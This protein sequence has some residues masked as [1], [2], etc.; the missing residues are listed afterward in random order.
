[1]FM[2]RKAFKLI[3]WVILFIV[4]AFASFLGY[5]TITEFKPPKELVLGNHEPADTINDT[6]TLITWNT[7]YFGLGADMDFFYE[8]GT[9][10]RPTMGQYEQYSKDVLE[11]IKSFNYSDFLLLQEVDTLSHRSYRNNQLSQIKQVLP[12]F[13]GYFGINYNAWVPIPPAS[14]MGKVKAGQV[15][16]SKYIPVSAKRVAFESSYSWPMRLF[17]LKRCY[18]ETR[19][20]TSDGKELVLINTHNSAFDDAAALREKELNNLKQLINAEYQ[21]GNYVIVGGD[22][23]QNPPFFDSAAVLPV[24]RTHH[25]RPG[26]PEDFL[27]EDWVVAYDPLHTTNRNVNTAYKE[28]ETI[29]NLIDFFVL[30]PNIKLESIRTIPTGYKESDHQ[31]VEMKVII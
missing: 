16:M 12:G 26:I 19:Y 28:G 13:H 11:R 1:M 3:L 18:V 29:S 22:W 15:T 27:E 31:P 24:Y 10:V 30:S 8:G 20:H 14:P 5:Q 7:G 9:M 17:Q 23:N 21:K 4:V 2:I 6:L 25:I